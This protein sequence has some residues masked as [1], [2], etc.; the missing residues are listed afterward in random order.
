MDIVHLGMLAQSRADVGA[1]RGEAE[2]PALN[3]G[4]KAEFQD[5]AEVG[6]DRVQLED[7]DAV[8]DKELAD[9]VHRTDR[10]HVAGAED[11][12]DSFGRARAAAVGKGLC[13]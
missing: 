2:D 4:S 7:D 12:A 8:L 1:S 3:E 10:G 11:E 5:R 6:V 9:D 13:S